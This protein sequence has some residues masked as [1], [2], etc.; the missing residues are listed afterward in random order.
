MGSEMTDISEMSARVT[1]AKKDHPRADLAPE[2]SEDVE[3]RCAVRKYGLDL[4]SSNSILGP[5]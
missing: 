3:C 4:E 2:G 1:L 5:N